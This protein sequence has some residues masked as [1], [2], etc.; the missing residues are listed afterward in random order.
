M[1]CIFANK[2]A[3]ILILRIMEI[4]ES[5]N[6]VEYSIYYVNIMQIWITLICSDAHATV[7]LIFASMCLFVLT[8]AVTLRANNGLRD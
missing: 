8:D 1:K 7:Q 2:F 6:F 3:Y 4:T 5:P